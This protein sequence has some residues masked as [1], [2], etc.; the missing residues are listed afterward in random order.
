MQRLLDRILLRLPGCIVQLDREDSPSRRPAQRLVP[1]PTAEVVPAIE[2]DASAGTIRHLHDLERRD[3]I[4]NL[5]PGEKLEVHEEP[6]LGGP[7][8]ESREGLGDHSSGEA[9]VREQD[10]VQ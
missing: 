8:T 3:K 4:G 5:R 9:L 10:R 2:H 7:V 6:V 1:R